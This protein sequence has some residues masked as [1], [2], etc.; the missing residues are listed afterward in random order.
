[1]KMKKKRICSS[2]YY[3]IELYG[4]SIE[5]QEIG[6]YQVFPCGPA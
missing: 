1:M 2:N 5:K 3:I 6:Y 4:I